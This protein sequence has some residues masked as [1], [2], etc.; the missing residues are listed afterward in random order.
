MNIRKKGKW[1]NG[2]SKFVI[3]DNGKY[4]KTLPP[5]NTLLN[6][7]RLAE[8]PQNPS[9]NNEKNEQNQSQKFGYYLLSEPEKEQKVK[10]PTEEELRQLWE[11]TK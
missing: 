11:I 3:E 6:I 7:L 4:I 8:N 5:V 2:E 1:A 9:Q 10:T